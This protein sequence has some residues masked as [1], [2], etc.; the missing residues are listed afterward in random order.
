M[1]EEKRVT[2]SPGQQ[3]KMYRY[4]VKT[5]VSNDNDDIGEEMQSWE[6]F[7]YFARVHMPAEGAQNKKYRQRRWQ[8]HHQL[9]K[10]PS[11]QWTLLQNINGILSWNQI[12]LL[13]ILSWTQVDK[14]VWSQKH[15]YSH[16]HNSHRQWKIGNVEA[17]SGK[18]ISTNRIWTK[19]IS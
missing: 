12:E 4:T 3:K 2:E 8:Q 14:L 18:H 16:G 13:W 11:D 17:Y 5:Y 10:I 6:G 19:C 7:C 9:R 15:R 1:L